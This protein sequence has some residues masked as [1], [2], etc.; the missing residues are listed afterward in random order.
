MKKSI[1]ISSILCA[2]TINVYADSMTNQPMI[3][4]A[5]LDR[6]QVTHPLDKASDASKAAHP[7]YKKFCK[8]K[9]AMPYKNAHGEAIL[10]FNPT[11]NTVQY[12]L[13]YQDLSGP[14]IMA[15]FHIGKIGQGGPIYQTICGHPPPGNQ[16]LGY[17]ASKAASSMKCPLTRSGFMVGEFKIKANQ[18]VS[19]VDT[20]NKVRQALID[21]K[22]YFNIHTCLNEAGEIRGQV[23]R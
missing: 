2:S 7:F 10:F 23:I 6:A 19:G 3:L 13:A 16:A 21:G 15:H 12:A 18:H 8:N 4:K 14:P 1:I 11:T 20:I 5:Q 22:L 9:T 17:S